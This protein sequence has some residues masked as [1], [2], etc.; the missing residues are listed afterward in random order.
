MGDVGKIVIA[1]GTGFI[2]KALVGAL[3]EHEVVVLSR[4]GGGV[5]WDGEHVG[6]WASVLEGALAVVNLSG[7]SI[8]QHWSEASKRRILESRVLSTRTI[9]EAVE[10]C[11]TPPTLWVNAS[12]VGYYGDTG[13]VAMDEAAPPGPKGSFLVDTCVAWEDEL[14]SSGAPTKKVAVR[15]GVVLGTS[16]GAFPVL[17][18]LARWFLGGHA[19]SG[20]QY[21]SWI[22]EADLVAMLKWIIETERE[23][24]FNATAPTPVTNRFFMAT[25]RAVAGRP[26][27]PPVPAWALRLVAFLGGPEASLLLEGQ[28]ALPAK[29]LSQGF[30]FRYRDVKDALTDLARS[31]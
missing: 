4:S 30:Q 20:S 1:G 23:G 29:A 24:V 18:R 2:G 13:A 31:V 7:E 9:G 17:W 28:N 21:M 27:S 12:A 14:F 11:A 8:S 6:P 16:G 26:W 5:T 10:Q 3:E 25:L 15:F 19:G 22:H